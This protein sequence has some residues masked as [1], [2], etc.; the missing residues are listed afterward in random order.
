M[1]TD[2]RDSLKL[3]LVTDP[4]LHGGR[5]V[6]STCREALETGVRFVQLR[7]KTA[8]TGELLQ[9]AFEL[10]ELCNRHSAWFVVNDRIDVALAC[11]AHGVHLGQSDMPADIARTLMGPD[12]VI[13]VS[14]RTAEEAGIA[15][16]N[17]ANYIAAN[18]VFTTDTKKD[19][20][21]PLGLEMVKTL[22][23]VC[24]LP[25]IAIGGVNPENT[26]SVMDAGC[27]GVAVVSAI[28][29]APSPADQ[30]KKFFSVLN[31]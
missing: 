30:V 22:A 28:M 4:V 26:S 13:G 14:V 18:L 11:R 1:K 2:L 7:D 21:K 17:G 31:P 27:S 20:G 25:L 23:E 9:S 10:R 3:Y 19:A 24:P 29:N 6:A 5:G 12:A 16:A 15:Y 8:T